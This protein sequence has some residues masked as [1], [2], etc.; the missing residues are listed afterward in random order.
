[1]RTRP[2][3]K[4][5][6]ELAKSLGIKSRKKFRAWAKTKEFPRAFSKNPDSYYKKRGWR[7]WKIFLGTDVAPVLSPVPQ[8]EEK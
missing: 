1:V 6:S 7:G 4:D 5:A 8:G 2:S 3:L